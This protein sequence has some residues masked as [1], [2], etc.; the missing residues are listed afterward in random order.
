MPSRESKKNS[1]SL[2]IID[3]CISYFLSN[4][5]NQNHSSIKIIYLYFL[6]FYVLIECLTMLIYIKKT[7]WFCCIIVTLKAFSEGNNF[8]PKRK[9]SQGLPIMFVFYPI[10]STKLSYMVHLKGCIKI[11]L[12]DKNTIVIFIFWCDI[13]CINLCKQQ[14]GSILGGH[15]HFFWN[16][17]KLDIVVVSF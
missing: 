14:D 8:W 11:K 10:Y 7:I 4:M 12:R 15:I 17:E 6:A 5:I 1:I 9:W 2:K 16:S 3:I 13:R